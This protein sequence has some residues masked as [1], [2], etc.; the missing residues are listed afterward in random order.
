MWRP[1]LKNPC[2]WLH[3]PPVSLLYH[4]LSMKRKELCP[5]RGLT[6]VQASIIWDFYAQKQPR[7]T[8]KPR[9]FFWQGA[10]GLLLL[11][12]FVFFAVI[13]KIGLVKT[14]LLWMISAIIGS[15][16]VRRQGL[17]TFI[18][19]QTALNRGTVPVDEIFDGF[20]LFAAGALLILPGFV[21]DIVAFFLLVPQIRQLLRKYI[22]EGTLATSAGADSDVIDG[23]YVRVEESVEFIEKPND[24]PPKNT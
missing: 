20:C 18:K 2:F 21:S 7:K 16:L 5:N 3:S 4:R 13:S 15:W 10:V 9:M 12:F 8:W 17:E 22:P 11:E 1:N 23:S 19:I 14:F 6:G 24:V